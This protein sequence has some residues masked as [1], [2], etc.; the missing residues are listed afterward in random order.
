MILCN[1]KSM[2]ATRRGDPFGY[3]ERTGLH[4]PLESGAHE[5]ERPGSPL[6]HYVMF[7]SGGHEV[8]RGY[9]A[10][11]DGQIAVVGRDLAVKTHAL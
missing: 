1:G 7:V 6:T 10:V 8:P 9:T 4:E 2:Y 5:R 11:E 3:V